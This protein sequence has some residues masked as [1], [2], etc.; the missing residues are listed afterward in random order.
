[1]E[2]WL[3][4]LNHSLDGFD[5]FYLGAM[6]GILYICNMSRPK[7][8]TNFEHKNLRNAVSTI[9]PIYN[10]Y[11]SLLTSS[12]ASL[13]PSSSTGGLSVLVGLICTEAEAFFSCG[14]QTSSFYVIA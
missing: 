13:E 2:K 12:S 14:G 7:T 4:Y 6:E 10:E 9:C 11:T 5:T 8:I 3:L 1:L